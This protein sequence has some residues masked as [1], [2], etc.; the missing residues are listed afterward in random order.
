[1][2]LTTDFSYMAFSSDLS[3][4]LARAKENRKDLR[5]AELAVEEAEKA[6]K[7]AKTGFFAV[8]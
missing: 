7:I 6:I 3:V 2:E 1:M 5:Q 8:G 4:C